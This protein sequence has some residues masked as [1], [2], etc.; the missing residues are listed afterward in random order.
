[1]NVQ[2]ADLIGCFICGILTVID[3][4]PDT[5]LNNGSFLCYCLQIGTWVGG[6]F[7]PE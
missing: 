6:S 5:T 7:Y 4:L 1:M 2:K 3:L